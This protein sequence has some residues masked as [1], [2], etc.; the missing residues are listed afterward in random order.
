MSYSP[1][2]TVKIQLS[3]YNNDWL[4]LSL[5]LV[6]LATNKTYGRAA[7]AWNFTIPP[8]MTKYGKM[9]DELISTNDVVT[10]AMDAGDGN[11]KTLVMLGLVSR[12]GNVWSQ[13]GEGR[14]IRS[15]R[16]N[17][18]DMG[19]LLM[20]H[21]CGWSITAR[22]GNVGNAMIQRMSRELRFTGT[23]NEMVGDIFRT[24]F[25]QDVTDMAPYFEYSPRSDD[26]WEI[27]N[28]AVFYKTGAVW[29]AM[30]QAANE[31][32]NIL[33]TETDPD[34]DRM[35]FSVILEKM[36]IKDNG[37]LDREISLTLDPVDIITAD[38]GKCDDERVNYFWLQGDLTIEGVDPSLP[39]YMIL[40][41]IVNYDEKSVARH[42][43][44]GHIC[45]TG[46]TKFVPE[47]RREATTPFLQEMS[48]RSFAMW[49]RY[50]Y[51]PEL[52][53]GFFKAHL[54]PQVR[55]GS[56]ILEKFT[57]REY[58]VET[59]DHS[60]TFGETPQFTT[61]LMVSRGQTRPVR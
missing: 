52:W 50:R 14:P 37:Y 51:N 10:I 40:D 21:D 43:Y 42:G 24:L 17:G 57:Q 28:M 12:V 4:D 11:G 49:N 1:S 56:A 36:P 8:R 7:G 39:T 35:K 31:E 38:I 45:N 59:V 60:M 15:V 47:G 22:E 58:F 3:A 55:A 5:D 19:K 16:I 34:P 6:S 46:F 23:A 44:N 30:K 41:G 13:D 27:F 61:S 2:A 20:R 54:R 32:W 9:Y 48:E 53:S 29:N 33:T 18:M 26:D 25:L